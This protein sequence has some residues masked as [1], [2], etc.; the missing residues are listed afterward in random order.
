MA[1]NANSALLDDITCQTPL[2]QGSN[3]RDSSSSTKRV[4]P[5]HAERSEASRCPARQIL[6]FAQDDSS[7]DPIEKEIVILSETDPSLRSG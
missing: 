3:E 4:Q 1:L 5:C 7:G 2:R 6:R